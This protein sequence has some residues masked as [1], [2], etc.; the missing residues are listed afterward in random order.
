MLMFAELYFS[1]CQI[2][3]CIAIAMASPCM[4]KSVRSSP[5]LL[6]WL[7]QACHRQCLV[8]IAITLTAG[9]LLNYFRSEIPS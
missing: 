3:L 7:H 8:H 1:Y 6:V 5:L 9:I 4:S 2:M